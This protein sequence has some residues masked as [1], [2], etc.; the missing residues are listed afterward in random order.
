MFRAV[1]P[2]VPPAKVDVTAVGRMTVVLEVS[3]P[4]FKF[5]LHA[6]PP[7]RADLALCHAARESVLNRLNQ[8]AQF[9]CQHSEQEHDALLVHRLMPQ[10]ADVRRIAIGGAIFQRGVLAFARTNWRVEG[11]PDRSRFCSDSE[12]ARIP[13]NLEKPVAVPA[14]RRIDFQA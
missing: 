3:A 10:P 14:S 5:D 9:F 6:L 2:I 8:V 7:F 13:R 4:K 1:V 11:L 12:A